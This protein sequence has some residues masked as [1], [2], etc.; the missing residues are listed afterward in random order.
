MEKKF[1]NKMDD[2]ELDMVVGGARVYLVTKVKNRIG[3]Y[4]YHVAQGNYDGNMN[5]LDKLAEAGKIDE[6]RKIAKMRD[7]GELRPGMG[8]TFIYNMRGEGKHVIIIEKK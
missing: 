5:D 2:M 4:D 6:L 1:M 3:S 7:N 8:L